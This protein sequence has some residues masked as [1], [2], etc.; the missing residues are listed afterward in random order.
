MKEIKDFIQELCDCAV[1]SDK[2]SVITLEDATRIVAEAFTGG[3]NF[4]DN[5][6]KKSKGDS[7]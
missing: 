4:Q 5:E 3:I 7:K 6:I 2:G 1:P